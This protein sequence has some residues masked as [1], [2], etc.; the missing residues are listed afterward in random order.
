MTRIAPAMPS[1]FDDIKPFP[2]ENTRAVIGGNE[3]PLEERIVLDLES[4]IDETP[5]LRTRIRDLLAKAEALPACTDEETAGKL[6]DFKKMADAASS[7]VE[8]FR[9]ALKEPVLQ[10]GRNLDAKARG[11]TEALD[12]AGM[13]AKRLID[14]FV[15]EQQRKA[16]E[17]A[18]RIAAEQEARRRA[19]EEARRAAEAAN[20]PLPEPE[21]AYEPEPMPQR[22]AK[23]APVAMGDMGARVGTRTVWKHVPVTKAAGLPPAILNHPKVLEAIN[24]VI[25]AQVR[26]GIRQIKGVEISEHTESSIR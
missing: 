13:K 4:Q 25:A 21:P 14:G 23:P 5:G 17:E 12:L 1:T 22:G 6:A 20:E 15:A 18:R 11:Y 19:E 8:S 26:S 9:K 24:A 7:R 3:P 10:A 16:R 2:G